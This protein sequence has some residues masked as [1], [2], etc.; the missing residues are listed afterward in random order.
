MWAKEMDILEKFEF[1][2]FYICTKGHEKDEY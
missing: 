1:P 2:E